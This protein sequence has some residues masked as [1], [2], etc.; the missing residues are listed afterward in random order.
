MRVLLVGET[1]ITEATHYK[2]WDRFST[3]TYHCGA[4]A[5]IS[6]LN[7]NDIDVEHMPA[8]AAAATFPSDEAGFESYN[9]IVLSDIGANTLLLHPETWLR[10]RPMHNRLSALREWVKT[11]GGVAMAGGYMSFQGIHG[12]ARYRGTAIEDVL[13]A[14]MEIGDDRVEVPE[15]F[16]PEPVLS[17]HPILA[18]IDE[19]WPLLLGYNRFRVTPDATLL[20][21]HGDDPLLAVREV[22][23]G[24]TLAWAS[25]IGPHW[26]PEEFSSWSG[27]AL[28]WTQALH[29]LAGGT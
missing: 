21:R 27:F 10:A 6:A 13:P 12:R 29:W 19:T 15:G 17:R 25:D 8:H 28:L 14:M 20:A 22:G 16:R 26:C 9:V 18:G 3:T 2:G 4:D 23:A 5:F 7:R 11:G 24:R 1:W